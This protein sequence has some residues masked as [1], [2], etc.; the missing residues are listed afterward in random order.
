MHEAPT[1]V[2]ALTEG[3]LGEASC[4]VLGAPSALSASEAD[5]AILAGVLQVQ[6]ATLRSR[7]AAPPHVAAV[8]RR[9]SSAKMLDSYLA[10]LG[11]ELAGGPDERLVLRAP[12]LMHAN[13]VKTAI[14]A[15]ARGRRHTLGRSLA[16]SLTASR[17]RD[18]RR[19]GDPLTHTHRRPPQP[20]PTPLPPPRL[21]TKPSKHVR[22]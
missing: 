20:T 11:S 15:Q 5:A 18:R 16:R 21:P 8:I 6:D 19:S 17:T 7:R 4:V 2:N 13:D 9:P 3:G 1:S 12:E 22:R 14:I 10:H